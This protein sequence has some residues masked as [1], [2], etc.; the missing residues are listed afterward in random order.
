MASLANY[1]YCDVIT[2]ILRT[3]LIVQMV[4]ASIRR[5]FVMVMQIVQMVQMRPAICVLDKRMEKY[6]YSLNQQ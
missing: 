2:E 5:L 1:N 3:R 4:C 6:N